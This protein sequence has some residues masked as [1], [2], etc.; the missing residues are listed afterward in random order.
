MI[1]K[2]TETSIKIIK[3]NKCAIKQSPN[4]IGLLNKMLELNLKRQ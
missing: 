3:G 4:N 2:I 1:A